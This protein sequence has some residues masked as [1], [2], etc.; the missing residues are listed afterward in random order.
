MFKYKT[1]SRRELEKDIIRKKLPFSLNSVADID[2][3]TNSIRTHKAI[4]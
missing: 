3:L 4:F 2:V 1:Y